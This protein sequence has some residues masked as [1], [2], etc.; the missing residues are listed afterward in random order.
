MQSELE[1]FSRLSFT[2]DSGRNLMKLEEPWSLRTEA[3]GLFH[4]KRDYSE[5]PLVLTVL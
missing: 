4:I 5:K 2:F 3:W 1:L